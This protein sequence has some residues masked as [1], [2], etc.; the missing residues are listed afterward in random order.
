LS[1]NFWKFWAGQTISN[2][3]SSVTFFALPLLV[4]KLTGSG[5][6]L[7]IASAASTIPYLLFSLPVGALVDCVD[8]KRLMIVTDLLRLAVI[9]TI[10]VLASTHALTVGWVYLAGF[11][12]SSLSIAFD[13]SEF[14]ALPSLVDQSHLVTANGRI[15]A[16]Y[17]AAG[18]LGPL[19]AGALLTLIPLETLFLIDAGTFG[20]SAVSLVL[21]PTSFNKAAEAK[22]VRSVVHDVV[23]GLRY[24]FGHP[25]LRA[26]SLL[27]MASNLFEVSAFA[28]LVLLAKRRWSATDPQIGVLY[29]AAGAG[30]IVFSLLAGPLRGRF[31]FSRVVVGAWFTEG[32]MMLGLAVVAQYWLG[33]ILWAVMNGV[34]VLFNINTRSLRQAIV[35]SEMLGRVMSVAGFLAFGIMPI[36]AL[37][38]GLI[39]TQTGSIALLYALCGGGTVILSLIGTATALGRAEQYLPDS[40]AQAPDRGR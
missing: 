14:A 28:Q 10:P 4:F 11:A 19:L 17:S 25:V 8:R 35:P 40:V 2:L 26:I 13:T 30:I 1:L 39:V 31:R 34:A 16:S 12:S 32:L 23:E 38:G 9:A 7:G 29:S 36:G 37:L 21:I 20:V 18:V 22:T 3:G 6:N 27:M 5:L 15:Q 33:L 24:V